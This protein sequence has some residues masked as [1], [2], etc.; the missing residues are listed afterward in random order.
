MYSSRVIDAALRDLSAAET[1][2][3]GLLRWFRNDIW[4]NKS[5]LRRRA[6]SSSKVRPV[7]SSG[8]QDLMRFERT[9]SPPMIP[10]S[11]SGT[12]AA[13]AHAALAGMVD[14][15]M[16]PLAIVAH[17][18]GHPG[19][20]QALSVWATAHATFWFSPRIHVWE[21]AP[22]SARSSGRTGRHS[23]EGRMS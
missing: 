9:A 16:K 13:P 17:L 3:A 7:F 11:L 5:L 20:T 1:V 15:L 10:A 12:A 4:R 18:M 21:Q 2:E 6:E 8:G 22:D 23:R 14:H 19:A